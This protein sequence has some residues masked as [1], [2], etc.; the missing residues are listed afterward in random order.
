M[1]FNMSTGGASTADKIKY[2]NTESG[3]QSTNV[4][5]AVDEL[6]SSLGG[7][8]LSYVQSEDSY[9]IQYGAD[10]VPKKLGDV[11]IS[12]ATTTLLDTG[13]GAGQ[14]VTIQNALSYKVFYGSFYY[15]TTGEYTIGVNGGRILVQKGYNNGA[16]R[17]CSAVILPTSNTTILSAFGNFYVV[18]IK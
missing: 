11:T 13:W 10:S 9:Y 3:L 15:N 17:Y 1:I 7:N 5:G 16:N 8:I 2:D 4:Q 18:G 14:S 12:G 6:N